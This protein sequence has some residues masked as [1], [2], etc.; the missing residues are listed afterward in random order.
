MPKTSNPCRRHR[1]HAWIGRSRTCYNLISTD[2]TDHTDQHCLCAVGA[3]THVTHVKGLR[4]K[5]FSADP[6][7]LISVFLGGKSRA[8]IGRY[9]ACHTR[10]PSVMDLVP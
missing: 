1:I 4:P 8:R 5:G 9:K 7:D 3:V 2:H 10:A 6:V